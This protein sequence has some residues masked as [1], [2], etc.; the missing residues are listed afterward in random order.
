MCSRNLFK[1]GHFWKKRTDILEITS[2]AASDVATYMPSMFIGKISQS[3]V[4]HLT[5][6]S[7]LWKFEKK[8]TEIFYLS[9]KV[10]AEAKMAHIKNKKT[11]S[12]KKIE[13]LASELEK[14]YWDNNIRKILVG[15]KNKVSKNIRSVKYIKSVKI[16]V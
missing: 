7:H 8:V 11:K 5:K 10:D 1:K 14:V 4:S 9:K 13:F 15:E 3:K 2:P 6:I 12:L 16:Q